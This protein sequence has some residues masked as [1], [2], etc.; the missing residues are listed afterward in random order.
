MAMVRTKIELDPVE[1]DLLLMTCDLQIRAYRKLS[2]PLSLEEQVFCE[3]FV[4]LEKKL[5]EAKKKLYD[6][7]P[8]D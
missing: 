3:R 4:K 7:P 1:V 5:C 2:Q 6:V 8:Y